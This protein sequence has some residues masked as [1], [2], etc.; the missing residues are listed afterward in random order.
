MDKT[1]RLILWN[2]YEILKHL[3]AGNPRDY[4]LKQEIVSSGFSREYHEIFTPISEEEADS[5]MQQET[6]DILGMFRALDRTKANGWVPSSPDRAKFE[7]F[8]G[9]NDDHYHYANYLLDHRGLFTESAPNKN[10]HSSGTIEIYRRMLRV[11]KPLA[12][13]FPLDPADAERIITA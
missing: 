8:D 9:N 12:N 11:W 1:T 10:S 4:E 2:Q 5:H 7:G 13:K 3:N 6:L